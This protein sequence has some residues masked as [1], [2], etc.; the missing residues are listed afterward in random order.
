MT[1]ARGVLVIDDDADH[2]DL[3]AMLLQQRD[4][5]QPVER[6]HAAGLGLEELRAH[7]QGAPD[8]AVVFIDRR[9]GA[10][11]SLASLP[12]L[13]AGRD[14]LTVVSL[15]AALTPEERE[16]A[17]AAGASIAAQKPGALA[18]WRAL[19]DRALA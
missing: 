10:I 2:L 16:Q 13:L 6:V 3:I 19:L 11:D 7:I 4:A 8:G 9:L 18:E 5:G 1:A 12:E 15:S 14:D 17:E